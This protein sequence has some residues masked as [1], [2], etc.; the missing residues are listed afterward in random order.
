MGLEIAIAV[1][2]TPVPD[3]SGA[4]WVEV[5]ER[6]G[7]TTTYRIRYPIDINAEGDFSALTDD[8]LGPGSQLAVIVPLKG[9]NNYLVKGPVTGQNVHYV[10]RGGGSY[11]E[12]NGA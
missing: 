6:M 7:E 3:L 10:H 8:R 11:V 2:D 12:V 4:D 1:G 5:H 9:K